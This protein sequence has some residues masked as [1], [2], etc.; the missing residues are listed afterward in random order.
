MKIAFCQAVYL[1]RQQLDRLIDVLSHLGDALHEWPEDA[2]LLA[3]LEAYRE[4]PVVRERI[5]A[6]G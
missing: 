2:D 5:R 3:L 6:R 4:E 1:D